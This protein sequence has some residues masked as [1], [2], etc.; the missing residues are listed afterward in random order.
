VSAAGEDD[1]RSERTGPA[2]EVLSD[3]A[4]G[5]VRAAQVIREHARAAIAQRG[6][7]TFAVSGGRTPWVVFAELAREH[8]PWS[9]TLVYQ[10]DE[11]IAPPGSEERNLTH[12]RSVLPSEA[13]ARVQPMPVEDHDLDAAAAHYATLLPERFDL[14]HLG[15]GPDGHTASLIPGDP[16]LE[17]VDR[18][19]ALTGPYQG[20]IRMTITYPVIERARALLWVVTGPDKSEAL[21]RLL[22]HD[23]AIPAGRVPSEH[24]L[25]LADA[26]ASGR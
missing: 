17:V 12:L 14:I 1:G 7:F 5:A 21:R 15:L 4:A 6:E 10:V 11:R 16:V 26:P 19:V 20:C 23:H 25:L 24:A 8:F 22:A 18:N 3:P 2:I 13:F 9:Q